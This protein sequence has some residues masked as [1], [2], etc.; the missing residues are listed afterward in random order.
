MLELGAGT[1]ASGI[2]AAAIGARHVVLTD[3]APE[4]VPLLDANANRN[5]QLFPRNGE[6]TVVLAAQWRFGEPPPEEA[7]RERG[8]ECGFDWVLG[9]D[10]TYSVNTDRDALARTLRALLQPVPGAG[11]GA[12][13]LA[14][15]CIIAHEHRRKDMFDVDAIL[16][17]E[18][19]AA[20]DVNDFCLE[21]FLASAAEHGLCVSP[22]ETLV[23]TRRIVSPRQPQPTGTDSATS[24]TLE[25][26]QSRDVELAVEMTT[27]LS[28][29]EVTLCT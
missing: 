1:G 11:G 8:A 16:R 19:P 3:G 13:G 27:D 23:G 24:E 2:F 18:P 25:L 5:R 15:R 10:I 20:W 21:T 26:R 28:I 6:E 9:S 29:F 7:T 22:L 14:P 12:G 17:D 4:L